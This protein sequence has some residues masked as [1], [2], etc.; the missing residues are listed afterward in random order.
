MNTR[1]S[2]SIVFGVVLM[3]GLLTNAA[4]AS[5][6][7]DFRAAFT[8]PFPS[9]QH[10]ND[11]S[12]EQ[13]LV[14]VNG[15]GIVD[16]GDSIR[17]V[18]SFESIGRIFGTAAQRLPTGQGAQVTEYTAIF[19]TQVI[20]KS[21]GPGGL[22]NFV[23][24]P[25]AAFNALFG[26]SPGTMIAFFDDPGKD[27][28]P[29]APLATIFTL[30]SNGNR[31]LDIGFTGAGGTAAGGEGWTATAPDNPA[32]LPPTPGP[33]AGNFNAS[34]NALLQ[35]NGYE[36]FI[37]PFTQQSL[38][39]PAFPNTQFSVNGQIFAAS[40]ATLPIGDSSDVFWQI[41]GVVPE[42]MSLLVWSGLIGLAFS[43]V[44]RRHM[45]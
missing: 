16:V 29:T 9:T 7:S 33:G 32:L 17:G 37:I 35:A 20:G 14:D 3:T 18:A 27:F 43:L 36:N 8:G 34:L 39:G 22:T 31:V 1:F 42:P 24:G 21:A 26:N 13:L 45:T 4:T 38:L 15:N 41:Q 28:S 5:I 6:T 40:G 12:W 44:G 10:D 25:D 11:F 19:A 30:A 2:V 23:M